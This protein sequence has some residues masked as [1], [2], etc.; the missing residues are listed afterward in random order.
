MTDCILFG[1]GASFGYSDLRTRGVLRPPLSTEF[2]TKGQKLGILDKNRFPALCTVISDFM[3]KSGKKL[4]D[5]DVEEIMDYAI[6]QSVAPTSPGELMFYIYELLRFHAVHYTPGLEDERYDNYQKFVTHYEDELYNVISLNYD[7]LFELALAAHRQWPYYNIGKGLPPQGANIR[8]GV[9]EVRFE[10]RVPVAKIHGS[11]NWMNP[12]SKTFVPLTRNFSTDAQRVYNMRY[13]NVVYGTRTQGNRGGVE[14]LP[15]FEMEI[16][17]NKD[18]LYSDPGYIY[19]PAIVPPVGQGK[20]YNL[21]TELTQVRDLAASM[22]R[23]ATKLIVIGSKLRSAD[24]LLH[25]LIRGNLDPNAEI[26]LVS[27]H[28]PKTYRQIKKNLRSN[29]IPNPVNPTHD[30]FGEYVDKL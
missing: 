1:A 19:Q 2:F 20:P 10:R 22:L 17:S 18:M 4:A 26:E 24:K 3:A 12:A 27:G 9:D 13:G 28:D 16:R 21:V 29:Q 30:R 5:L 11:I 7:I 8:Y 23:D 15:L 14:V 6:T 25:N